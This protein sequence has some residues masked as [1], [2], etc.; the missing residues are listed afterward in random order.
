MKKK[1]KL[2]EA[3][4]L[5]GLKTPLIPKSKEYALLNPYC[6]KRSLI[7]DTHNLAW[8]CWAGS[9]YKTMTVS[10]KGEHRVS[11]HIYGAF[12]KMFAL[13]R[14][15]CIKPEVRSSVVLVAD[16]YNVRVCNIFPEYKANREDKDQSPVNEVL[17]LLYTFPHIL[18]SN[19]SKTEEADSIISTFIRSKFGIG[20][21]NFVLSSDRDMWQLWDYAT[22]F[23][24]SAKQF[25]QDAYEAKYG[26][27]T[28]RLIPFY[29]GI[30]GDSS[31]NVPSVIGEKTKIRDCIVKAIE[32]IRKP[33]EFFKK[34]RGIPH[35]YFSKLCE[36]KDQIR[37]M[38][39]VT[40]FNTKCDIEVTPHNADFKGMRRIL[41]R[42]G[43]K[44]LLSKVDDLERMPTFHV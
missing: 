44:S 9:F 22:F 24:T 8:K 6:Y 15:H 16:E 35:K 28:P 18:A 17:E 14:D 20:R 31:D 29:K 7:I 43:C 34:R 5:L 32:S 38:Y 13:I 39:R 10:I 30:F 25:G 41:K 42:W 4:K 21:E 11:G 27:I 40:K 3:T 12:T 23:E 19:P 2:S 33:P 26:S 37:R 1:T 36:N